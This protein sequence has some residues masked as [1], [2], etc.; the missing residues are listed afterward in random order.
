LV[1]LRAEGHDPNHRCQGTLPVG[2]HFSEKTC[3]MREES[4]RSTLVLFPFAPLDPNEQVS[5]FLSGRA[6]ASAAPPRLTAHTAA[7]PC[8]T[9]PHMPLEEPHQARLMSPHVFLTIPHKTTTFFD[10]PRE[11][12]SEHEPRH[13]SSSTVEDLSLRHIS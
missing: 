1:A 5:R 10:C 3:T 7:P 2:A 6:R 11:Q 9:S 12:L 8:L 4:K 13:K